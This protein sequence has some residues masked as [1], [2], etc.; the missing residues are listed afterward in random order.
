MNILIAGGTGFIGT[1]LKMRFEKQGDNVKIVSR[2]KEHVAWKIDDLVTAL[3]NT[4]VLIN[5]AGKSINCRHSTENKALILES[6]IN[7]TQLL[8]KAIEKSI[9]PPSLWINASASAI[10]KP[11]EMVASVESSTDFAN[12]FL[13][14]VVRQW[15]NVFFEFALTDTRQIALRTSV[16]LGRNSGAFPSLY[17]LARFGL[18]GKVGNGKQMFSWIHIEDYFRIVMFLIENTSIH[19]VIN[20]TSPSPISNDEL[21]KR[22]RFHSGMYFGLPAPTFAVK[23][24]ALLIG[25]ESDLLLNSSYLFPEVLTKAHFNFKFPT[26]DSAISDLLHK[27]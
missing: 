6:R 24:G 10:Y 19:S 12:D 14:K 1:Y 27:N 3:E 25:T 15:E 17:N 13:S 9:N 11:S 7:T 8:G 23:I 26:I 5:L 4:D 2:N 16:V 21:M 18:G 20:C 22:M